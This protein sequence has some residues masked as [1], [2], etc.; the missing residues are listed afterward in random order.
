MI[1]GKGDRLRWMWVEYLHK[2]CLTI[3]VELEMIDLQYRLCYLLKNNDVFEFGSRA[4]VNPLPS[5]LRLTPSP[6]S[7][8]KALVRVS[9]FVF[10][11]L[12]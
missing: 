5:A 11:I 9:F 3:I 10:L 12:G 6:E 7:W 1:R 2:N 4:D 8:G